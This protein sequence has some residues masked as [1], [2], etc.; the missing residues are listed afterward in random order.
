VISEFGLALANH[1]WQSTLFAGVVGVLTLL[2]RR[3]SARA[4]YMLWFTASAKFLV[5]LGA[6]TVLGAKIPWPT[7]SA[8]V[9]DAAFFSMAGHRAAQIS[10]ISQEGASTLVKITH[11]EN[12][13][14]ILLMSVAVLWSLGTLLI[15][16]HRYIRWRRIHRALRDSTPSDLSFVIPVRL[17]SAHFEPGVVGVLRPVLLLPWGLDRRLTTDEMG[18]ILA[19]EHCHVTRADNIGAMLHMLVEALFWFHPLI[20][21]VGSRLV[22]ERE[23]AC[24]EHVLA[25]GHSP[26]SYAEGILKVCEHFLQS[27]LA[28]VA[29]ISGSN[30][31]LRIEEIMKGRPIEDLGVVRK[32]VI[33]TIVCA[34]IVIPLAIPNRAISGVSELVDQNGTTEPDAEWEAAAHLPSQLW[35]RLKTS[36]EPTERE[37]FQR[38]S[39]LLRPGTVDEWGTTMQEHLRRFFAE[40]SFRSRPE[41]IGAQIAVACRE[42]QC[43]IQV[44]APQPATSGGEGQTEQVVDALR[45]QQWYQ[46][47]L[48]MTVGQ[49]G[50]ENGRQYLVQ[51]F[52]RKS[53]PSDD[54]V[55]QKRVAARSPEL[56]STRTDSVA[57]SYRTDTYKLMF[58]QFKGTAAT[59]RMLAS[60]VYAHDKVARAQDDPAWARPTERQLLDALWAD[61]LSIAG[62]LDINSVACRKSGCEVQWYENNPSAKP[63]DL[64]A[65][66]QAVERIQKSALGAAIELGANFGSRYGDRIMYVTT[67]T[68][69]LDS[70]SAAP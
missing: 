37:L 7:H 1:V 35:G 62:K 3:N 41:A 68:R 28:C 42:A 63:G 25:E 70:S 19:H 10:Q 60:L 46:A 61:P 49:G 18:A 69:K 6:L 59:S 48:V 64:P 13:A 65:W 9:T 30:L 53:A 55:W 22:A 50:S 44:S 57:D 38:N 16:V 58:D 15:M 27:G 26:E 31:R 24:D 66:I 2:L 47:E 8:Q 39:Q 45:N 12:Y 43:Q 54:A 4:R 52:D 56:T 32:T 40:A 20:W 29:S 33:V 11:A 51:Y 17:S 36:D 5:P 23:R 21:W 67:F 14:R 34:A